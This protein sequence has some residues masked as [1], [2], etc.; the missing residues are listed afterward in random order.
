VQ[1]EVVL[2]LT[3]KASAKAPKRAV[4]LVQ[5]TVLKTVLRERGDEK[6]DIV[7]IDY[8]YNAHH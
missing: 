5:L 6:S 4:I 1:A 7:T 2:T 8:E 3:K